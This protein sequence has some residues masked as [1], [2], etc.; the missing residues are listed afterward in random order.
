MSLGVTL[1]IFNS[2]EAVDFYCDAFGMNVGYNVKHADGSYLHAE[3]CKDQTEGF[4]V[5]ES[6][7][8]NTR[9]SMLIAQQPT[10]SLG[11]NLANDVELHHAYKKL[12]ENGHVLRTLGS[13]PWSPLSADVVDKYGVCWYIYVSQ[14]RPD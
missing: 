12:S 3:L 11:M 8:I 5:S 14:H 7:D 10:V 4:A 2:V 6:S 13:L 9:E 1:Y